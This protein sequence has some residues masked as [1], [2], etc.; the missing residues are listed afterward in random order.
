MKLFEAL[1]H[2]GQMARDGNQGTFTLVVIGDN[3]EKKTFVMDTKNL[4]IATDNNKYDWEAGQDLA[5]ALVKGC[6]VIELAWK[7]TDRV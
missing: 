6:E 2:V 1:N 4:T 5:R 3:K 7:G